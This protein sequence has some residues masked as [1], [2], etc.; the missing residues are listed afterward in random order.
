MSRQARD[1]LEP[2]T[3]SVKRKKFCVVD[4]E[5]K[6]DNTQQA[7]F[8]RPFLVGTYDPTADEYVEFKNEP[9][10]QSRAWLS[11]GKLCFLYDK[12][13][14]RAW[15]IVSIP[16]L[17]WHEENDKPTV[18]RHPPLSRKRRLRSK[19]SPLLGDSFGVT[20]MPLT[21][22]SLQAKGVGESAHLPQTR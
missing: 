9:H 6:A 2:L 4:I 15:R 10:L 22:R 21:H 3:G 20:N 13:S 14:F 1:F 16:P 12:I 18:V 8:T 11:Q 17:F 5:T 7:G 19:T